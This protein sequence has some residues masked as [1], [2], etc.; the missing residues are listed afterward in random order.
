MHLLPSAGR[1]QTSLTAI[2]QP[3]YY[4]F[5]P[6]ENLLSAMHF[7]CMI[8]FTPPHTLEGGSKSSSQWLGNSPYVYWFPRTAV[9]SAQTWWLQTIGL[10]ALP[11]MEAR[12]AKSKCQPGRAP[13]KGGSCWPLMASGGSTHSWWHPSKLCCLPHKAFSSCSLCLSS[14][15]LL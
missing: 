5:L 10:H 1:K 14:V 9:P 2:H 11:V 8:S 7:T 3:S 12:S 15:F 4:S 13:S 6:S